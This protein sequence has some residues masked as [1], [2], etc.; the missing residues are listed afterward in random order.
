L[1]L[2]W[3][4]SGYSIRT[5][6]AGGTRERVTCYSPTVKN[7]EKKSVLGVVYSLA[8]GARYAGCEERR[9]GQNFLRRANGV[10]Y[11]SV[12]EAAP[13]AD[14]ECETKDDGHYIIFYTFE[15]KEED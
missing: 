6:H 8:C 5:A 10:K 7:H 3:I 1:G 9:R 2:Y 12:E 15:G 13:K 11:A 14:K 4:I